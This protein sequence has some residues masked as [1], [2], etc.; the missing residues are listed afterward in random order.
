MSIL[1]FM[2]MSIIECGL[3]SLGAFLFSLLFSGIGELFIPKKGL[4]LKST[5]GIVFIGAICSILASYCAILVKY[6]IILSGIIGAIINIIVYRDKK[7][8]IFNEIKLVFPM[9]VIFLI[10]FIQ[11][12]RF[13][14][15]ENGYFDY[16]CHQ[17]YFA[18]ISLELL[19]ADY[20]SR[21]RIIDVYPYEWSK[22]HLFNGSCVAIPLICFLK[23]NFITFLLAKMVIICFYIGAIFEIFA[24][25]Y[26]YNKGCISISII[27]SMYFICA[28]NASAWSWTTNNYT[29]IF[30]L[31]ICWLLFEQ[32]EY[33]EAMLFS[34]IFAL[35][36]SGAIIC[37]CLLTVYAALLYNNEES[38]SLFISKIYKEILFLSIICVAIITMA[39]SGAMPAG[40]NISFSINLKTIYHNFFNIDWMNLFPLG[41]SLSGSKVYRM[42]FEFLFIYMSAFLLLKNRNVL[43][44]NKNML[45]KNKYI[46]LKYIYIL[47][48]FTIFS[49]LTLK[50]GEFI[51][52]YSLIGYI[53]PIILLYV[54]ISDSLYS[55]YIIYLIGLFTNFIFF[56]AAISIPVYG[57]I[58]FVILTI[59]SEQLI[60]I[61]YEYDSNIASI[62][63]YLLICIAITLFSFLNWKQIYFF[64][65]YD[66][67]YERIKL[68]YVQYL[69]KPFTYIDDT[70]ANLAK[71]HA[72]K[73]N[74]ITYKP[75]PTVVN[76]QMSRTSMSMRFLPIGYEKMHNF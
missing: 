37:G 54:S 67:Y 10:M 62:Y 3:F 68:E 69:D 40:E 74:R 24:K 41:G 45:C 72:L 51:L 11:L 64:S 58:F 8:N 34:S 20:F 14:Y 33:K 6:T 28:Y 19:K 22:Y 38:V 56:N 12:M 52:Q 50:K 65:P 32:K 2:E 9:I 42:H 29:C 36:R 21:V 18:G 16:N 13:T 76:Q 48:P 15:P 5:L 53:I 61:F 30:L 63:K 71:L 1:Q 43:F 47:F 27:I 25:K 57:T 70:S 49:I 31:V 73:G 26:N 23:T 66:Y 75:L 7:K 4:I 60:D 39:L 46:F 17:T 44:N 35:S 59:G 55:L